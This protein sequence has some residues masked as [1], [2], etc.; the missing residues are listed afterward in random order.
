MENINSLNR[1]KKTKSALLL[2]G[3]LNEPLI[4]LF[5]ILAF[6]LRKDLNATLFQISLFTS[7]RPIMSVFSFYWSFDLT[8]KGGHFL[9]H[10]LLG[11]WFLANLPILFFPFINNVWYFIF[12]FGIYFLFH[13]AGT[14]ALM[15]ILKLNLNRNEREKLFSIS[16]T[17]NFSLSIFIGLFI[18]K[19]F[20]VYP[21][22]WKISFFLCSI[23]G[24][25]AIAIQ[26]KVPIRG[27]HS[28]PY[29]SFMSPNTS[30]KYRLIQPWK[31]S[32][33]LLKRRPDFLHFQLGFMAGGCGLMLMSPALI[34]YYADVL[35]LTYLDVSISRLICMGIGFVIA[36]PI[37]RYYLSRIS[38]HFLTSILCL[39]FSIFP[40]FV[41]LA[42]TYI[43]WI[44]FAFLIYG[45]TQAGSTLIWHLSGPLFAGKEKSTL[46]STVNILTVGIRG[47]IAPLFG[48]LLC[49]IIGP[50]VVIILG[51]L[52][53]LYGFIIMNQ[54]KCK[55]II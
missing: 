13:K 16:S 53:C 14:P 4:G 5:S 24:L 29:P 21:N 20:D 31:D 36:S 42:Q 32:Y 47:I 38:I 41:L 10:N 1:E 48:G 17:L 11:A 28:W 7:L 6:I 12:S 27:E 22:S 51:M 49:Q 23:L 33:L 18:G 26:A 34:F 44:Y 8:R 37:W 35:K 45:I 9:R 39:G 15:E 43:S 52:F 55:Q 19:F 50:I 46:F 25:I 3:L 54:K 40:I 2:T 30:L